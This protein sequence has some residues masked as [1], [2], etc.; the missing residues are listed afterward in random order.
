MQSVG[1]YWISY[2]GYLAPQ[3]GD[4]TFIIKVYQPNDE[5]CG[6]PPASPNYA[7]VWWLLI[8]CI[9]IISAIGYYCYR[10]RKITQRG[11]D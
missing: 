8:V 9:L 11:V 4:I 6:K 2:K 7:W 5:D 3:T 10:Q 1:Y